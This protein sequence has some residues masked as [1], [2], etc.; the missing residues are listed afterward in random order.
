[1]QTPRLQA[2]LI[3]DDV[4]RDKGTGKVQITGVFDH[5]AVQSL[6]AIHRNASVYLR[7]VLPREMQGV[8]VD[9]EIISPSG[10]RARTDTQTFNAS[11]GGVVEG[12]SSLNE[13]HLPEF[14]K[15]RFKLRVN[16]EALAE[17]SLDVVRRT[18]LKTVP[19]GATVH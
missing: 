6:P 17:Y 11:A 12:T 19:D 16:G 13:I 8:E 7:L 5:I 4:L 15:Y 3:C 1:M 18:G 9:L 14:G 10:K 2:F